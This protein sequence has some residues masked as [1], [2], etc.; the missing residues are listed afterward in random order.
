MIRI[1]LRS[2]SALCLTIALCVNG[3]ALWTAAAAFDDVPESHWAYSDVM[4]LQERGILQGDGESFSPDAVTSR[5]VFVSMLCRAAGLDDRNL[6]GGSDWAEPSMAYASLRGWFSPDEITRDSWTEPVTRELAA[7]LVLRSL[8]PEESTFLF[9]PAFRDQANV[10]DEYKPYVR[11]VRRLGLMDGDESGR[12]LPHDTMT[13]AES[14][15]LIAGALRLRDKDRAAGGD[16]VQVPVLMYH[17]VSYLGQGYSKTPEQFRAQMEELKNAGFHTVFFSQLIDYAENGTPLPDKSIVISIDDGY[18]S[19]YTYVYPILRELGMKAEISLIGAAMESA[20]WSLSWDE[21]RE[22]QSSGLVSF[23]A[24]ASDLHGDHS[25]EGGR[26]GVLK[27]EDESWEDYIRVLDEDTEKIMAEVKKQTGVRPQVYTY[28][29]GMN[30]AMADAVM[31]DHGA[32]VT[33][34]TRNGIAEVIPGKPETLRRMDR[35]G[36]DFQNGSVVELLRQY[37]YQG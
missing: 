22:M 28:P 7:M 2:L 18:H 1:W 5:Q 26:L 12:F 10:G 33:L 24:H 23:Q 6:Q 15:A 21:V 16:G 19:N 14:A 35:I 11:T 3:L 9:A 31:A 27:L 29:R 34:T 20:E 8:L 36:M 17:D 25:A 30:N 4:Y 37:G 13:R 32:K